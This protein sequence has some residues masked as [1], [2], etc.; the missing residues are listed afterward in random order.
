MRSKILDSLK[1]HYG[2]E[3]QLTAFDSYD[4]EIY[5]VESESESFIL[6]IYHADHNVSGLRMQVELMQLLDNSLSEYEIPAAINT[7]SG[8]TIPKFEGRYMTLHPFLS[9][10]LMGQANPILPSTRRSLGVM[11]GTFQKAIDGVRIEGDEYQLNWDNAQI[12]WMANRL[13]DLG[14]KRD[15]I[16]RYYNRYLDS[17]SSIQEL[18]KSIIHNDANEKQSIR[19]NE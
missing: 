10:V 18:R 17:K 2:I 14:E 7:L 3:G 6:K 1:E 4:D 13:E 19:P 16:E 9:G 8:E 11:L 15:L 12:D 5:R